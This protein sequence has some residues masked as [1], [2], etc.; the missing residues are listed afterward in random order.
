MIPLV[1]AEGPMTYTL[2]L[3]EVG[4]H[5][6]SLQIDHL[7]QHRLTIDSCIR[8]ILRSYN[9]ENALA[10]R[11]QRDE[12]PSPLHPS[13]S[14]RP[15]FSPARL[16]SSLSRLVRLTIHSPIVFSRALACLLHSVI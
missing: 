1:T 13:L 5:V 11:L 16:Q 3:S 14:V 7:H 6:V 9:S 2:S 8:F 15:P 10:V 12:R 4:R